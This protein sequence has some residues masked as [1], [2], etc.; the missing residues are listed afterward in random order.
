MNK[1][2]MISFMAESAG[3]TK[4]DAQACLEALVTG[5]IDSAKSGEKVAISGLGTFELRERA[6]RK[7]INPATKEPLDIPASKSVGFKAGKQLKD[8]LK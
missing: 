5:I 8:A 1:S 4:K 7:G 3:V 2:E 6:A